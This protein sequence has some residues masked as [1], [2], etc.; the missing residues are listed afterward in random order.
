MEPK[1]KL[2]ELIELTFSRGSGAEGDPIRTVT[3]YVNTRGRVIFEKDSYTTR[4]RV[5]IAEESGNG[6]S[7]TES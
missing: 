5:D 1:A 2:V 4:A 7:G 3:Q 6:N